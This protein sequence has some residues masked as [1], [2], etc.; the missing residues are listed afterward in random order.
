MCGCVPF[1]GT[2]RV[3]L[4]AVLFLRLGGGLA[5]GRSPHASVR[6]DDLKQR[7]VRP[8]PR[9][10]TRRRSVPPGPS[11][12]SDLSLDTAF[13]LTFGRMAESRAEGDVSFVSLPMEV[14][15]GA[16]F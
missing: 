12:G 4:W 11:C 2:G 9:H 10:R 1:F 13:G 8:V 15:D 16:G 6:I 7:C 5:L 3:E 14:G